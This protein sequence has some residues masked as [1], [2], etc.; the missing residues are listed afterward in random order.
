MT[1]RLGAAAVIVPP[2]VE[3]LH[4][5]IVVPMLRAGVFARSLCRRRARGHVAAVF[6]RSFHIRVGA[7]FLCVGEP[8]IGNG[9]WT[10]IADLVASLSM[11]RLSGGLSVVIAPDAIMI[12]DVLRFD[13]AEC[14][15]WRQA[16]WPVLPSSTRFMQICAALGERIALQAPGDGIA[17]GIF[18]G[19]ADIGICGRSV[20]HGVADFEAWLASM[21]HGRQGSEVQMAPVAGLI[22]LGPGL[23]PSGDDFLAGALALL[24]AL[25]QR[26]PVEMTTNAAARAAIC[27]TNRVADHAAITAIHTSLAAT[28]ARTCT[29]LTSPFSACLLRAAARGQFGEALCSM[30]AAVLAGD[31]G[32]AVAMAHSVG[33][34]SGWDMLSGVQVMLRSVAPAAA[35]H[36]G[37]I[38]FLHSD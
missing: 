38:M 19:D 27:V 25:A 20:R 34:S 30:V 18:S 5:E 1:L 4:G 17:A 21:L 23:T 31:I 13:L 11:R 10:L 2:R 7:A 26:S 28:V 24:N 32:A 29:K 16:P 22:G 12:G 37:S 36:T 33:H 15:T 14:V 6:A 35:A 8:A 9:P 3:G